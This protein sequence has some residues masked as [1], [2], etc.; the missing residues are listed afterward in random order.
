MD[1]KSRY[2]IIIN[3]SEEQEVF[4]PYDGSELVIGGT[5]DNSIYYNTIKRELGYLQKGGE[6]EGHGRRCPKRLGNGSHQDPAPPAKMCHQSNEGRRRSAL[7]LTAA[8]N[9]RAKSRLQ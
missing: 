4:I 5:S 7:P 1:I 3:Y 6:A 9:A 2:R 8:C